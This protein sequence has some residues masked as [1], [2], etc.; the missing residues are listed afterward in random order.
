MFLHFPQSIYLVLIVL[1]PIIYQANSFHRS[2]SWARSGV[3]MQLHSKANYF[4]ALDQHL[5]GLYASCVKIKC[6]FFRR[7]TTDIVEQVQS[8]LTFLLLR[9]K[10]TPLVDFILKATKTTVAEKTK[11]IPL[12][13]LASI[14]LQDWGY[15]EKMGSSGKGYYLTGKLTKEIYREDCFFDGPD[16]DMPVRGLRK[17]LLSASQLFD[18]RLSRADLTSPLQVDEEKRTIQVR[19]R[20]EGVLKLPWK[21]LMK[22]WTGSTTYY[23][24]EDNL[25]YQHIETWDISVWDAFLSTLIP[26]LWKGASP[27]LPISKE[28]LSQVPAIVTEK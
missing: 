4:D 17:Y 22:P 26:T 11:A 2:V 18:S 1:V 12:L 16:P 20:I 5:T 21:P 28:V 15:T 3:E 24:D 23:F 13:D 10:S 19:W 9:H 8:T 6:P 25:V 27:A 14:I 7:R